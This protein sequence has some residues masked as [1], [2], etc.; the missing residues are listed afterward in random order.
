MPDGAT[1]ANG[2][3]TLAGSL[4][5]VKE[6]L[7]TFLV[8]REWH[9]YAGGTVIDKG[10]LKSGVTGGI[11]RVNRGAIGTNGSTITVNEEGTIDVNG[12]VEYH[13]YKLVLNGGTMK[14]GAAVALSNWTQWSNVSLEDDSTFELIYGYGLYGASSGATTLDLG[15]HTLTVNL[16]QSQNFLL[17][18]TTVKN[19]TVDVTNG[20]YLVADRTA[21]VA[22]NAD[23]RINCALNVMVP[24][25]VRNY[26]IK[27][28][29]AQGVA[30][31]AALSRDIPVNEYSPMKIKMAITGNGHSTKN[32]VAD[33]LQ[34]FLH[35]PEDKMPKKLDATDALAI[36]Y[37][38]FLQLGLPISGES[39]AK[40]WTTYAKRKGLTD[41]DLTGPN[42]KLLAALASA[43]KKK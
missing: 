29:H 8:T 35:I 32:Q 20:G 19:G 39:G 42:A 6:G 37:C 18:H 25:S 4:K 15:G 14:N 31:A 21:V 7:G 12:H 38:H 43:K 22:T 1:Y 13:D 34:R 10:I 33:M 23:F 27:I 41:K 16:W 28:V 3:A 5:L 2:P 9:T 36:A 24:F 26:V 17:Y 11:A 30:I 40:D